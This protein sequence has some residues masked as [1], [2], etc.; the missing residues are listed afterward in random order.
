MVIRES[1]CALG[2]LCHLFSPSSHPCGVFMSHGDIVPHL[3]Q[4]SSLESEVKRSRELLE[5]S[6]TGTAV[7][8]DLETEC[9]T[10]ASRD[11]I[12]RYGQTLAFGQN[13]FFPN[14]FKSSEISAGEDDF[15]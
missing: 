11:G 14:A 6:A 12:S 10:V 7:M 9:N 3:R 2:S 8:W 5:Q 1:H 15:G 4:P 13:V